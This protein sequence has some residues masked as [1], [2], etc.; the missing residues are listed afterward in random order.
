MASASINP[1]ANET[2]TAN[3][4]EMRASQQLVAPHGASRR[5]HATITLDVRTREEWRQWLS[6]HHASSP[7][8]WLVRHKQRG[9]LKSM[10][11]E[12]LVSEALCFGWIDSLVKRLDDDRF[13]IKV[14]PRRKA[15]KWSDINRARWKRLKAEGLLAPPGLA[16]APT[17][18]GYAPRHVIPEL[19]AYL[20]R[21][22]MANRGGLAV[23]PS[24]RTELPT[25]FRRVDSH[26]QASRDA[27]TAYSRRDR[28]TRGR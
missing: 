4:I 14:T 12:D 25:R 1:L 24:A 27:R 13:A 20:A 2:N 3:G 26:R 23:L 10:P 16:A 7:G 15:S 17:A 22:F 9:G 28:A 21:A 11:Y 18:R 8:I 19:P 6:K 5:L